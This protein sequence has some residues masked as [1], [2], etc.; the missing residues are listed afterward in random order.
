MRRWRDKECQSAQWIQIHS[1]PL[2]LRSLIWL[3]WCQTLDQDGVL[4]LNSSFP[5]C[6]SHACPQE[7]IP[8]SP[9]DKVHVGHVGRELALVMMIL[10][11]SPSVSWQ[12]L[13]GDTQENN[14]QVSFY[15]LHE[16]GLTFYIG[17]GCCLISKSCPTLMQPMDGNPP[18]SSVYGIFPAR[19]LEWLAISFSRVS[20]QPRD[21][22]RV[23]L[24]AD[25]LPLSHSEA[26]DLLAQF[27]YL[28]FCLHSRTLGS[29]EPELS[30]WDI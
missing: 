16:V 15:F 29:D 4:G 1:L 14:I 13:Q 9:Q 10:F 28:H 5:R 7:H 2:S 11:V 20:S 6:A 12:L 26:L 17:G 30:Q 3:T 8:F 23:S 27:N 22:T 25:S 19:I 21:Q 24:K 18:G